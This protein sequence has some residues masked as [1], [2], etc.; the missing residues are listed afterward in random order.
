[1]DDWDADFATASVFSTGLV[2]AVF[3]VSFAPFFPAS[4][5]PGLVFFDVAESFLC[6]FASLI[7]SSFRSTEC[8]AVL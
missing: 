6:V 7:V 3:E 8:L 4:A 5:F 2:S 1:M